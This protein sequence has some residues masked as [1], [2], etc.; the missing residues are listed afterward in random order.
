MQDGQEPI[1]SSAAQSQQGTA[2]G[3][4][5]LARKYR[6]RDF[7]GLIGQEALVRTLRNAIAQGRLAHGFMLTGV[8]GV[9]KTTTARILARCFNCIGPDGT[10]GPTAEP[11][12]TCEHCR[13]IAEDRHVDVIEMDAAS[14]TGIDDIRELIDGVRYRPVSARYKVYIIDEVH[15]L[16]EKAFNALLK[17]L[18]EP[19][20]HVKFI[21]ATTEIRKVPV[22]VL[23]RCQRFD[24]R[25]IGAEE[26][27]RY[28][29][30][31]AAAE[32]A[33]ITDA[34]AAMIARAAD[35]SARD[36]LSLL[37]QAIALS[38]GEIDA[39]QVRDM[40][41]LADRTQLI[42]L[43]DD[44]LKGN[45]AEALKRLNI[46]HQCGADAAIVLQD[47]LELTHW[48]TRAKITPE[49][50]SDPAT[51]EAERAWGA[52]VT[53]E[54]SI[55]ILARLWQMLL[56]GLGEVQ[57]APQ[58]LAAAEMVLI[59]L[60]HAAHMP[61]PADLVRRLSEGNNAAAPA[62]APG[63]RGNGD[64]RGAPASAPRL[65]TQQQIAPQA[66]P[67]MTPSPAPQAALP[68]PQSFG[69]VVALFH[70]RRE[71]ILAAH[72]QNDVHLVQFEV[73]RIDFR[74]GERAPSNLPN[75]VAAC[76]AEWTGKRWLVSV[77]AQ[78]GEK[79]LKE[80]AAELAQAQR[81]E[82]ARHPLVQA[83]LQAFP[84]A[85]IDEV[86]N[87][88]PEPAADATISPPGDLPSAEEPIEDE[89]A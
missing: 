12:G 3:Y 1:A 57:A 31:I 54:L 40:L 80:Q 47:M 41:G 67:Q 53:P 37:D 78:T 24:L 35:G 7:A 5:V 43:Y 32:G 4:R 30:K 23:S 70:A 85:T 72:L 87:L 9:G 55:P 75:R 79:T 21:F 74:P 11:C 65:Q 86:R 77:S 50:L 18:E 15:M 45:A 49:P 82:A 46:M 60:M 68:Q 58:P 51:P 8:R 27:T 83:V 76:L 63:P 29:L 26:L 48:L 6:P 88:A 16:S 33:R 2:E 34:A 71:A 20:E 22:T 44:V 10:G 64:G 59:R 42:E 69:E 81:E 25:R 52:R 84:G 19:P 38:H 56:K 14:R 13:A 73:G 66:A 89:I 28:F 39:A 62:S 61:D 36:G 17:T